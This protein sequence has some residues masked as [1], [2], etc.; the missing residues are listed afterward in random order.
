MLPLTERRKRSPIDTG[1][2]GGHFPL[3][4]LY[5]ALPSWGAATP[6]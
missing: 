3:L 4:C 6:A 5:K 2:A 1:R